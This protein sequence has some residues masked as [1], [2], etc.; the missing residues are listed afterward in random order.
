MTLRLWGPNSYSG[1]C[2]SNQLSTPPGEWRCQW[3]SPLPE[4]NYVLDI[5]NSGNGTKYAM[6]YFAIRLGR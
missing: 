2:Q 5:M 4:G 6:Y 1:Q 3:Q